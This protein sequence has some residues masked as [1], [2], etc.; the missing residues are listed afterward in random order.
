MAPI[1]SRPDSVQ[2]IARQQPGMLGWLKKNFWGLATIVI[3]AVVCAIIVQA[4]KKPGQ[5]S[6]IESQAMDMN[7]MVPPKG[8][9]PVGVASVRREI[10]QGSVTYTGT[11]QAYTDEDVYPRVT[12][13]VVAMPVYPGDRV[14][15]GQLLV[16]L[17]PS[18]NSEYSAKKEEAKSAEDAA[19]HNAGTA[20]DEFDQKRHE[21]EAAKQ[22]EEAYRN[23]LSEAE[24][25]LSYWTPEVERQKALFE[26][27][28]ISLDEYQKELSELKAAQA[29][30][31][32][33]QAKLR[34][35]A[36]TRRAAQ[37]AFDA[38]VHHVGHF[39]SAARQAQA[40]LKN[41]AI[42][43]RYTRILAQDD[44]VVT[45]RIISPGVVV[46]P[47]MLL[48]KVAH[49]KKVRVQAEVANDDA[50]KLRLGNKAFIKTSEDARGEVPASITAIF[51][52]ADPASRTFTVEALVDNV[53]S[54]ESLAGHYRY[55]PG[56]YVVMRLVT[57][58]K[59]ALV[60]PATAV[61]W[62]EG[63]AQV[64]KATALSP[65]AGARKYQCP[66]HP[67][68]VSDKPGK[69]PKCGM[70][71]VP[72][73]G[74][75]DKSAGAAAKKQYTCTM[76]PEVI[77]DKPGKCPKCGMDLVPK[78]LGGS[79]VA[80][81]VNVEV[82]LSNPDKVEIAGGLNE[83]DEVIHAGFAMLKPGMPV[84][85]TEWGKSGPARLPLASEVSG[86]RLD[87][88]NNWTHEQMSGALMIKVSLSPAR[89]GSNSIVVN[90]GKHG[91]GTVP[92]ANIR[93]KTSMPGMNMPG[94]DL[95]GQT[96]LNGEARLKSDLMSGLW[97]LELSVQPPG[98][99][100]AAST[101]DVE[102]P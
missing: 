101:L 45:K 53:S 94:P 57:G 46:N 79:K 28:V 96:G 39:S 86:N 61:I 98:D 78:E 56:Q 100:A 70:D 75:R 89:G 41:A 83:G 65:D 90:V 88:S 47:G 34:E 52:A 71:L 35:A 27:K 24:A 31:L 76:H 93:I 23:A 48:L 68:V 51:P 50:Y 37:A 99:Q 102:V 29:K 16:Q 97:R 91:G 63:K 32:Q 74:A 42:Y 5:M 12:G 54:Q 84:V 92:G 59:A 25:S 58:E 15:K 19:M 87:A 73:T 8:A 80:T 40:A 43:E 77:S 7:A 33:A 9:V 18:G 95:S 60:V 38:A 4:L 2:K 6:V 21:L 13:R 49:I 85:A 10:I 1:D 64:W 81:L 14:R 22:A 26:A 62:R 17:D 67:E 3:V 72:V 30:V 20:R 44:G 69:C 55:L 82:G 11:V 36:S 66:M